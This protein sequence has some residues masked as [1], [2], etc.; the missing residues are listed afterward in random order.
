MGCLLIN[1]TETLTW[2]E[3]HKS[4]QA[5]KNASLVEI[6][7]T[8]Q[9]DYL[10]MELTSI[11]E[12]IGPAYYWTGGTDHGREGRWIWMYSLES[13][14]DFVWYNGPS[15]KQPN[16]GSDA[17]CLYLHPDKYNYDGCDWDCTGKY[18][19]ICQKFI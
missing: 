6:L 17:N 7:T 3:A 13:V 11:E 18:Y 9:M 15:D 4:C 5:E 16:G 14:E 19:P 10:Q 8:D 1:R 2:E 12:F